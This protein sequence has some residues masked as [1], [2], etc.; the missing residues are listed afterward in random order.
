MLLFALT[1]S[2][3][4]QTQENDEKLPNPYVKQYPF[5][6]AIITYKGK[7]EY[8]HPGGEKKSFDGSEIVY[9]E[10]DKFAK[11]INMSLPP[12]EGKS[13]H[14]VIERIQIIVPEYAYY[15]DLTEG[16]GKKIDNSTKYVKPKYEE[17]T[18]E[19]KKDF[20]E[21]LDK[22]GI[23][24]IDITGLGKKVGTGEILGKLC[25]IYEFGQKPTEEN[26]MTAIEAQA[27]PPYY[28]KTWIWRE[29]KIPLKMVTEQFASTSELT[30]TEIKENVK[31][32][33]KQFQIPEDIKITFDEEISEAS[34][35]RALA[36]FK[37]YRTGKAMMYKVKVEEEEIPSKTGNTKSQED[38]KN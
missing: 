37:L 7:T 17:L 19:E 22:R 36:R 27:P 23:V 3:E 1:A 21:R 18:T 16:T 10:G 14:R 5:E 11:T 30:V 12:V 9:I 13:E 15:I 25:D 33:E 32:P 28:R 38:K 8:G 4:K 2:A 34:K 35:Q 26:Y 20:H 29:A 31:I 24:S 6:N